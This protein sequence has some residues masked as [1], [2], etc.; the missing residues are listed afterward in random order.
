M[1]S[2]L[3]ENLWSGLLWRNKSLALGNKALNVSVE[4]DEWA[5]WMALSAEDCNRQKSDSAFCSTTPASLG[6]DSVRARSPFIL[7]LHFLQPWI[8]NQ[9]EELYFSALI[10]HLYCWNFIHGEAWRSVSSVHTHWMKQQELMILYHKYSDVLI[11]LCKKNSSLI[12]TVDLRI[13]P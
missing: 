4:L 12:S 1:G 5:K 6:P 11:S 7:L 2:H 8:K 10:S 13:D 9:T 3:W